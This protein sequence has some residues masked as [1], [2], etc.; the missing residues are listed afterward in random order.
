[1]KMAERRAMGALEDEIMTYLWA[2]DGPATP[3]DVHAAV[4]PELAYTTVMTILV[5]LWQK[6]LLTRARSG[7]AFA[8][9]PVQSEAEDR[10]EKMRST[11]GDAADRAAVLSSFV[12][13]LDSSDA[14]VLKKLL[15]P[16]Q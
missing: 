12:D 4:A 10:A 11:L 5:R 15:G 3:S 9:K 14:A 2:I 16:R 1:M 13:A 6:K 7:R 8:Y